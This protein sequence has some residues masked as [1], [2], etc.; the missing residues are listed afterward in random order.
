LEVTGLGGDIA[1]K[2]GDLV[3]GLERNLGEYY[4]DSVE[5]DLGVALGIKAE[6]IVTVKRKTPPTSTTASP[7]A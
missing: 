6:C 3:R 5:I 4:V 2:I 7:N 1:I